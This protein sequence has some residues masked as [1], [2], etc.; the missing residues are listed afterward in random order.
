MK[1]SQRTDS[2]PLWRDEF[3]VES[4]HEGLVSRRQFTKF[5]TLTSLGMFVGNCWILAKSWLYKRPTYPKQVIATTADVPV[6]GVKL[7]RYPTANDPCIMVRTAEDSFVA[8]S[9]KCTHLACPVHFSKETKRLECPC[10][11]GSFS[12]ATGEVV[13]GP[14]PR[15]LPRVLLEREN[16]QVIAVGVQVQ[17]NDQ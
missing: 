2:V 11:E 5:L 15:P 9:Q 7:F 8:Y 17:A 6:G 16:D 13:K 4:A 12:V 3:S 10:H 1:S 14:P